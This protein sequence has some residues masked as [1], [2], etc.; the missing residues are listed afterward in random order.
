MALWGVGWML[1]DGWWSLC[2]GKT[3]LA[4]G[5]AWYVIAEVAA[6]AAY[7]PLAWDRYFLPLVPA[8]SLAVVYGVMASL[9]WLGR[10]LILEP[11]QT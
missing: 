2:Q 8:A 4:W 9:S 5:A 10:R 7:V 3:P 11:P 6:L 1:R